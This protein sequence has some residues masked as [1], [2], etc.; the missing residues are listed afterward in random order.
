MKRKERNQI[1]KI[2]KNLPL[3]LYIKAF[4]CSICLVLETSDYVY[5]KAIFNK[6]VTNEFHL[7]FL[8]SVCFTNIPFS[9]YRSLLL[10]FV[11]ICILTIYSLK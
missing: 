1:Y 11:L 5:K 2:E 3:L 10:F 4:K 6:I 7:A 8:N 9:L